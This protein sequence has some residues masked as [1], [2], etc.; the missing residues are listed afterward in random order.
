MIRGGWSG[1]V[2]LHKRMMPSYQAARLGQ[3]VSD[4]VLIRINPFPDR[5]QLLEFLR[6]NKL[7]VYAGQP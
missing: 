7:S 2:N 6:E 5:M 3:V 1:Y 4:E